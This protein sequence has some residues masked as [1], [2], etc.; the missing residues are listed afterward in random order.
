VTA[1]KALESITLD[2]DCAHEKERLALRYAELVYFGQWFSPLR[3]ALDAFVVKLAENVTGT[4]TLKLY[5]GA[6]TVAA[7]ASSRSLY[8][9]RL[10]SFDMTGY[11]ASD[12]AGF[13]R[14]FGLPTRGRHRLPPIA[15]KAK[16]AAARAAGK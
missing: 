16:R 6:A 1:L 2:R 8:S 5:K 14:L 11:D 12:S 3:E 4:V 13:I 15:V 10:A 9:P 7:R